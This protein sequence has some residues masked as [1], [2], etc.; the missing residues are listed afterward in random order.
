M[1]LSSL[2][3]AADMA[4][5]SP[6]N[7]DEWGEDIDP[8]DVLRL[9]EVARLATFVVAGLEA[10]APIGVLRHTIRML[11]AKLEGIEPFAPPTGQSQGGGGK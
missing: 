6:L 8:D 10:R 5:T 2:K 1:N 3:S 9:V 7:R 4:K 11:G